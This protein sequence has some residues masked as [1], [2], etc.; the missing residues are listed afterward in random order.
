MNF[1][2]TIMNQ[3]WELI[4][5][6]VQFP[7]RHRSRDEANLLLVPEARRPPLKYGAVIVH[8]RAEWNQT[9]GFHWKWAEVEREEWIKSGRPGWWSCSIDTHRWKAL[10]LHSST[11]TDGL[12]QRVWV[13]GVEGGGDL[14]FRLRKLL[15]WKAFSWLICETLF[16]IFV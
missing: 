12:W 1:N 10:D 3:C 9:L 2:R 13:E 6:H 5:L 4:N 8:V 14:I 7:P 11:K 15:I 16:F